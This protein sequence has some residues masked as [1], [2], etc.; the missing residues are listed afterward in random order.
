MRGQIEVPAQRFYRLV[1]GFVVLV[2]MLLVGA[3]AYD[4]RFGTHLL[5]TRSRT[6]VGL[7][8]EASTE[9]HFAVFFLAPAFGNEDL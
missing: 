9:E 7:G 5:R 4:L 1:S 3:S 2:T 8:H 6:E